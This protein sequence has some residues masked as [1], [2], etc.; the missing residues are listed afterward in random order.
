MG[1][2]GKILRNYKRRGLQKLYPQHVYHRRDST[3]RHAR[4]RA[5]LSPECS[6]FFLYFAYPLESGGALPVL[7]GRD[8]FVSLHLTFFRVSFGSQLPLPQNFRK[9]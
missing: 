5:A 9:Q 3:I 2:C 8:V 6:G 7:V 4:W 1:A